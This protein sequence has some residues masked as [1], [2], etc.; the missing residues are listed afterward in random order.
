M[1]DQKNAISAGP[2]TKMVPISSGKKIVATA[3]TANSQ[4]PTGNFATC[5]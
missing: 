3:G 1:I 5:A 4:R 2:Q